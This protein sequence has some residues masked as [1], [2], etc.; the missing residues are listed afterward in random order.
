MVLSAVA[1]R[2]LIMYHLSRFLWLRKK[3]A[4]KPRSLKVTIIF[5]DLCRF[6]HGRRGGIVSDHSLRFF[7]DKNPPAR[8]SK[9][10]KSDASARWRLRHR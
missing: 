3:H 6:D 9:R 10:I 1:S 2:S 5:D 4:M 7:H 8:N